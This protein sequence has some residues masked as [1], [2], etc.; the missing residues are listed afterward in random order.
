MK[1]VSIYFVKPYMDYQPGDRASVV[2]L[3]ARQLVSTG[4]ASMT[5]VEIEADPEPSVE[6]PP[7]KAVKKSKVRR[8][9]RNAKPSE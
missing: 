9:A 1:N 8:K 6:S 4:V 7:N 5:P 3:T 2:V